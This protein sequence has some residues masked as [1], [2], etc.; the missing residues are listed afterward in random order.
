MEPNRAHELGY[1]KN[2]RQ[3]FMQP[4]RAVGIANE[5]HDG[6]LFWFG[7][8]MDESFDNLMESSMYKKQVTD[9]RTVDLDILR[10]IYGFRN[11]ISIGEAK[12][13]LASSQSQKFDKGEFVIHRGS[14]K[15]EIF[16]VRKGLVR[17]YLINDKGEEVTFWFYPEHSIINDADVNLFHRP[18]RFIYSALEET[19]TLSA[20]PEVLSELV[21]KNPRMQANRIN[22]E[23]YIQQSQQ[24]RLE[25]FIIATPEQRYLQFLQNYPHLVNRVPDKHLASV[26]GIT[27]VSLSRIRGRI[28]ARAN[29]KP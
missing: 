16:L 1:S 15:K 26:L 3:D 4:D 11:H 18:S 25:S 12:N 13:L 29:G 19:T 5:S 6:H 14:V 28:A 17:Q 10:Q 2:G 9:I 20:P 8:T 27:A 23:R 21:A 22:Y 24:K 7:N